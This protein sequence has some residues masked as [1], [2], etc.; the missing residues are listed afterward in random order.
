MRAGIGCCIIATTEWQRAKKQGRTRK[1]IKC[2]RN[3]HACCRNKTYSRSYF[4][5][6]RQSEVR[7]IPRISAVLARDPRVI[8]KTWLM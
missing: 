3:E 7:S 1:N 4:F 5:I 8:F 2:C 6:F